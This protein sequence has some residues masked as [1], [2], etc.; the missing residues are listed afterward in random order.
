MKKEADDLI[1]EHRSLITDIERQKFETLRLIEI[2]I[3][4]QQTTDELLAEADAA[5]DMARKA[6]AK[7]EDL[8]VQANRT[9]YILRGEECW[10]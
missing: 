9:L 2:G 6:V 7:A 1:D 4:E 3:R 8:L 10:Q 5:R